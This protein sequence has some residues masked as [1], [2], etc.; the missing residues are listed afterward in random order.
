MRHA[1][2]KIRNLVTYIYWK[3]KHNILEKYH[4]RGKVFVENAT[5]GN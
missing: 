1:A 2:L 4:M 5:D 3:R